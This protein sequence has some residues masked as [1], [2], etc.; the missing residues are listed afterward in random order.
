MAAALNSSQ[1]F[2]PLLISDEFMPVLIKLFTA[3]SNQVRETASLILTK[4]LANK[5]FRVKFVQHAGFSATND[6]VQANKAC[7]MKARN[8]VAAMEI[9]M[10]VTSTACSRM[11]YGT[12]P[13]NRKLLHCS[14]TVRRT[15]S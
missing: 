9:L 11:I 1:A 12:F 13:C 6:L 14:L 15:P 8:G 4:L 3:K 7:P 2:Y 10:K 5:E